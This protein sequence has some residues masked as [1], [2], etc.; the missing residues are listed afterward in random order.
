M[1]SIGD[2]LF[3]LPKQAT[4]SIGGDKA[5]P[6]ILLPKGWSLFITMTSEEEESIQQANE[7]NL[8][9]MEVFE[10]RNIRLPTFLHTINGD[11]AR[12]RTP[13]IARSRAVVER[14]I[15]AIKDF[16][17]LTNIAFIS[18]QKVHFVFKMVVIIAA[19]CNY[20]LSKRGKQW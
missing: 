3:G 15:N 13:E 9:S 14:V 10:E 16:L 19:I 4:F 2:E 5:Y 18:K 11:A 17:I 1:L 12:H 20:N 8:R 7:A 6:H